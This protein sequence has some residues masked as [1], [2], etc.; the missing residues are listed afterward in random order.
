MIINKSAPLFSVIVPVYNRQKCVRRCAE[1]IL[2]QDYSNLELI[3]IDDGSTDSSGC[4]CDEIASADFRVRAIHQPNSG[5][6]AA[7][8]RG[9]GL[10]RGDYIVFVDGDDWLTDTTLFSTL[11][12]RFEEFGQDMLIHG[13]CYYYE[14]SD[15]FSKSR[16]DVCGTYR[17]SAKDDSESVMQRLIS[18]EAF[19]VTPWAKA[20]RR[21]ILLGDG[22]CFF[23]E[24]LRNG[25]DIEWI[26]RVMTRVQTI[27]CLDGSYYAYRRSTR[28]LQLSSL[29]SLTSILNLVRSC[30]LSVQHFGCSSWG[31][32]CIKAARGF[33]AYQ[34]FVLLMCAWKLEDA[35]DR[36]KALN[37]LKSHRE[38]A[39]WAYSKKIKVLSALLR[40]FGFTLTPP[41][42][43]LWHSASHARTRAHAQEA[44]PFFAGGASQCIAQEGFSLSEPTRS[45][46][47][48]VSRKKPQR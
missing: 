42:L 7:R 46:Q 45:S 34:F 33:I 1:S 2:L 18:R 4:I 25:E 38:W 20:F 40:V 8:N 31:D 6:A 24:S 36:R 9:L 48:L 13:Y 41:L 32:E 10:A 26:F 21:E 30:E 22:G 12:Q 27:G 44:F 16:R 11:V 15:S 14:E 35:D 29:T 39:G 5:S 37:L 3:L 47:T 43:S 23:D 17:L 28:L 19:P